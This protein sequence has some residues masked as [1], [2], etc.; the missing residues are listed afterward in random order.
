MLHLCDRFMPEPLSLT[1]NILISLIGV[2]FFLVIMSHGEIACKNFLELDS[3]KKEHR[4]CCIVIKDLLLLQGLNTKDDKE[5][6]FFF[7]R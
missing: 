3:G 6:W 4:L 5:D 2:G 7:G 1:G